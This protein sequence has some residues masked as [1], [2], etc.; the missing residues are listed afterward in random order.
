MKKLLSFGNISTH[1][2]RPEVIFFNWSNL[3]IY[4]AIKIQKSTKRPIF[5][6]IFG[7]ENRFLKKTLLGSDDN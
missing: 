5:L 2:E 4:I 6:M 1:S 3:S 7:V